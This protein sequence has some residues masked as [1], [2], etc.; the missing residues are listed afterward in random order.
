MTSRTNAPLGDTYPMLTNVHMVMGMQ[1]EVGELQD[2]F[3]KNLAYG[4]KIDWTNVKEE[5]GDLMWYIA[6]FCN[7]NGFDLEDILATNIAKLK[8]RYPEKFTAE[9]AINRDTDTERQILESK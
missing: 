1:T 7:T 6:E 2:V 5:I 9:N 3:K 8:A 4:K